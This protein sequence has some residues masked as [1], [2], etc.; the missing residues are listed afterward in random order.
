M[1][2][3]LVKFWRIRKNRIAP[4]HEWSGFIAFRHNHFIFC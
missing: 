4:R 3:A 2:A 1:L